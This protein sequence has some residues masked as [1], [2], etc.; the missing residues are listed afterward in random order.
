MKD[1]VNPYVNKL[2]ELDSYIIPCY[3]N[4]ITEEEKNTL[5]IKEKNFSTVIVEICS[6]S[7]MHLLTLAK[8][9]PTSLIIG[10]ELRFKR[11]FMTAKKASNENL[12]N[13]ILIRNDARNLH[14]WLKEQSIS[15]IFINFPDPWEKDKWEKHRVL[16]QEFFKTLEKMLNKNG[17]FLYKT[18]HLTRFLE[19]NEMIK[20]NSNFSIS[21][22]TEDLYDSPY[23]KDNIKTEF[24]GLFLS[25]GLKINYLKSVLK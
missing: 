25:K 19:V 24:E 16:S 12:Q 7:G 23:I 18:D 14:L 21:E 11:I 17:E 20:K 6:G 22:Y 3:Y 8:K 4:K 2:N 5:R 15:K 1:S 10:F 9:Y 13:V